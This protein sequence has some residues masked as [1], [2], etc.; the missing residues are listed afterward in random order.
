MRASSEWPP[1]RADGVAGAVEPLVVVE[2]EPADRLAEA[3][4][5]QHPE[6]GFRVALDHLELVRIELRGLLQDPVG[7]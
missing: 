7:D 2:H 6:A 4:F 5:P 3:Q 1:R